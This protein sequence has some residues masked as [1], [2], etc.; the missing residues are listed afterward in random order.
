MLSNSHLGRRIVFLESYW[1]IVSFFVQAMA[2]VLGAFRGIFGGT[3]N[4]LAG[5]NASRPES[6]FRLLMWWPRCTFHKARLADPG[7][8]L[9]REVNPAAGV[10]FGTAFSAS[11]FGWLDHKASPS[12]Y[13]T[14][15]ILL[16][17]P[18]LHFEVA[19]HPAS[20]RTLSDEVGPPLSTPRIQFVPRPSA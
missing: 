7:A 3:G 5:R 10:N 15:V 19:Y 4:R 6:R 9:Q 16:R 1:R 13:S 17:V 12:F 11:L 2:R 8:V 20:Q 18:S 14:Q